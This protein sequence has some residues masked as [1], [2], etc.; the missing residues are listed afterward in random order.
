MDPSV[1][2]PFFTDPSAAD[3]SVPDPLFAD[4]SAADLS[5]PDPL[6]AEPFGAG[7]STE[8]PTDRHSAGLALADIAS[9]KRRLPAVRHPLGFLCLPLV[10]RGP[11]GICVHL[12]G[13]DPEGPEDPEDPGADERSA[14]PPWHA[15]SWDLHSTVLYGEVGNVGVRVLDDPVAP[16]HR[17]FAVHSAPDGVDEIRPTGRLVR[18]EPGRMRVS[19]AGET[20]TLRAGEFHT[21]VVPP[22]RAAATL[23]RGRS[24]TGGRDLSLG[25]LDGPPRRTT[26]RLC[27]TEETMRAVR[28]ALGRIHAERCA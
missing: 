14:V 25:P 10:R 19:P 24:L 8:V 28:T 9:G 11:H 5:V 27:G 1:P 12:F 23:V 7:P 21:T 15:H 22:G 13:E 17:V 6:F 2:D 3:L 4:P 26:R 16:T 18:G 20:Y